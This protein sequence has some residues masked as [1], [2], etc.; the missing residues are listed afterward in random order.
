MFR[1]RRSR[2]F[3]WY[4]IVR[5]TTT[6]YSIRR[7]EG[8][9]VSE[10]SS[11]GRLE[12][13]RRDG[14]QRIRGARLEPRG[15][16]PPFPVP[17]ADADDRGHAAGRRVWLRR[18]AGANR[19]ERKLVDDWITSHKGEVA[20][21]LKHSGSPDYQPSVSGLRRILG[22]K[23][24]DEVDLSSPP[25]A[26]DEARIWQAFPEMERITVGARPLPGKRP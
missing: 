11:T 26:E 17:P 24:V 19:H 10:Y 6:C 8:S 14:P 13:D 15:P 4:A 12:V 3:F 1:S 23:A 5:R 22:D 21:S 20:I 25:S 9:H 16:T 2:A 18:L 7:G